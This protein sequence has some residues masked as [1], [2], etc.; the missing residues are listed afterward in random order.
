MFSH[1]DHD[2]QEKFVRI[3]AGD[4]QLELSPAHM[5]FLADGHPIPAR[6]VKIGD[7]LRRGQFVTK[8]DSVTRR[9]IYAPVTFSGDIQVDGVL[10]SCFV[11][12]MDDTV[13]NQHA[14]THIILSPVRWLCTYDF[15]FCENAGY[16]NDGLSN[17]TAMLSFIVTWLNEQH[18]LLQIA[19]TFLTLPI[20]GV[21]AI[22]DAMAFAPPFLLFGAGVAAL[23]VRRGLNSTKSKTL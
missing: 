7:E 4:N 18:F 3:S 14:F 10:A 11:E 17:W 13:L 2:Y 1:V 15:G 23:I 9:G 5:V 19:V 22:L 8:L 21:L 16:T 6:E 12:L 20:F